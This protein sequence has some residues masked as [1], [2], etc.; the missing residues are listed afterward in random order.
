N[1]WGK[2]GPAGMLVEKG[3]PSV[4]T[5]DTSQDKYM[6][7]VVNDITAFFTLLVGIYFPSV[8]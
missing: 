7:Y 3:I 4:P 6:P 5:S 1:M 2:Y 8:T